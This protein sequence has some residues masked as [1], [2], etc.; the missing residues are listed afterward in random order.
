MARDI[1]NNLH[2][3]RGISPAAAVVDNT[4]FVSQIADLLGYEA[5]EFVIL[6]GAL[7]D[8]DAT[9]TTLVEHGD[10]AN[11]S[12][13]AAVPDDQLIGLETQASFTFADDDKVFKIGYRGPKRYARV[14]VTPAANAGNA[15]VAGVW[16]LGHPRNRPTA[17]PPA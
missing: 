11:L 2:V 9:F 14:T 1:H 7:A 4:P 12:D 17:N 6:T 3:R 15:F 10:A 8:A 13:A 5:A 16:V